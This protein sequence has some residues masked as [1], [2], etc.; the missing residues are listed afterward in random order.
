MEKKIIGIAGKANAGKTTAAEF[1]ANKYD[2]RRV[3]IMDPLKKGLA[4]F[5]GLP[6][7]MFYDQD[8]KEIDIPEY[9]NKSLRYMMQF[10][11]TECF[12]NNFGSDFWVNRMLLE[13][14]SLNKEG[15]GNIVI[16]D[17][18]FQEEAEMVKELCGDVIFISRPDEN[19]IR[20][21]HRSEALAVG[22]DHHVDNDGDLE[23]LFSDVDFLVTGVFAMMKKRGSI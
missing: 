8:I 13:I 2:F 18:R 1:I 19:S 6:L 10:V 5:T 14:E 7:Q 4:E 22:Y 16:D 15:V 11:G 12:R 20:S 3:A 21:S 17:I 23:K 9:N